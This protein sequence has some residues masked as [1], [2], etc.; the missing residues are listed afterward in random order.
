MLFVGTHYIPR[1]RWSLTPDGTVWSAVTGQLRL[2]Q[3]SPDGDTIRI[4]ETSHRPAEFD[5]RDLKMIAEGLAET[6][7]PRRDDQTSSIAS[8]RVAGEG[9]GPAPRPKPLVARERAA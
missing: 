2:V 9:V 8:R 7:I 5:Q 3:T 1:S 4:V 6:G